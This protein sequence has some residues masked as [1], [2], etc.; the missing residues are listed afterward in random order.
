MREHPRD[1]PPEPLARLLEIGRD[2]FAEHLDRPGVWAF[3]WPRFE[4]VAAW[5]VALERDRRRE[6]SSTATEQKGRLTID[7]PAG[8]F[9]VTG[10]AD[11]ID[12][13][14]DG[15]YAIIDY[16]TGAYPSLRDLRTGAAPQ[17]PLEA[18]MLSLG[19]FPDLPPGEVSSLAYWR[20][21]GGDPPGC[22]D[23][24]ES[25]VAELVA[26][27]EAGLRTLIDTFDDP[28]TPY[29]AVPDAGRR[30]RFNDYEHLART[31]EC[32]AGEEEG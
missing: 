24:V 5:F 13:L 1:L 29:H 6:L 12:R 28:E 14:G 23:A 15:C 21:G 18:L 17:L 27:A 32:A 9:V 16:K 22:I 10:I 4:R 25:G 11:R 7:G 20:V 30:P 26:E 3:W 19:G 8:P 2:S 31:G